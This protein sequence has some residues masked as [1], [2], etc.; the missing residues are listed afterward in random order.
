MKRVFSSVVAVVLA[1]SVSLSLIACSGSATLAKIGRA[2]G[3]L[4]AGLVKEFLIMKNDGSIS[5]TTYD[6]LIKADI[7]KKG[8]LLGD[9]L[10]GIK[11]NAG[12]K[13]DVIDAIAEGVRTF[14]SIAGNFKAGSTAAKIISY[15]TTGLNLASTA[16]NIFDAPPAPAS[17]ALGTQSGAPATAI[18]FE[19]PSPPQEVKKYLKS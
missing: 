10:T 7:D 11:I 2:V 16:V 15:L 14:Q 8:K 1:L 13:Q 18:K 17:F 9:Y 19:V 3:P 12:N 6:N 5:Q 4:S